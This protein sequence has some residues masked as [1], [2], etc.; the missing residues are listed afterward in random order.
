MRLERTAQIA[1]ILSF[2]GVVIILAKDLLIPIVL[3]VFVWFIIREIRMSMGKIKFLQKRMPR[4]LGNLL[5][6]I[7]L[8]SFFGLVI[9]IVSTN[10]SL[11][12]QKLPIYEENVSQVI[13]LINDTFQIDLFDRFKTYSG[14]LEF[15]TVL[16]MALNSITSIFGNVFIILIYILFMLLEESG[17]GVK[18]KAIYPDIENH[19]N[20]VKILEKIDHSV[21]RY[22]LLKT[23][24]SITTGL[25]SFI[26]LKIIGVDASFFWAFLIFVLNFIPTIGS[27][28][29]TL[30]PAA[31]ALLQFGELGPAIWVLVIIG[32]I[33]MLIGNLLEPKVMGNSLNLSPLVVLLALAIWGAF[34]GI[35]GMVL[36]VPITVIMLILFS[37]FPST[38]NIAILLSDKG[39]LN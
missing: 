25:L 24:M 37:E 11:L 20:T 3:A 35:T 27:L 8:F 16:K 19:A 36:S 17:F 6:S 26:V 1:I 28:I 7:F 12:S 10:I 13:R 29:A 2:I 38:R 22:L 14:N 18:L 23:L 33:Q 4:W 32:A 5:S 31:F 30:F 21:G 34:W 9:S 39:K 15:S